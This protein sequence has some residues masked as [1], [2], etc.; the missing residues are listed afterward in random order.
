MTSRETYL[1]L[2]RQVLD[3]RRACTDEYMKVKLETLGL[4]LKNLADHP[5]DPKH[6][7]ALRDTMREIEQE[8]S[9]DP[10]PLWQSEL[11]KLVE[12]M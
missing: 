10:P 8:P 4:A 6:M 2:R 9:I 1:S 12:G 11:V 5:D 7:A 3:Q